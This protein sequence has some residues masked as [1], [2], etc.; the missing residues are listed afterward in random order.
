MRAAV[1]KQLMR[2]QL[3]HMGFDTAPAPFP[4]VRVHAPEGIVNSPG[5]ET[6]ADQVVLGRNVRL[7]LESLHE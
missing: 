5:T 7:S 2:E 6:K 4:S 1:V 3:P